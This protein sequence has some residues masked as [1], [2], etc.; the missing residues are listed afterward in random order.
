MRQSMSWVST[1][2][3]LFKELLESICHLMRLRH[4]GYNTSRA[5]QLHPVITTRRITDSDIPDT[6]AVMST[7]L[8]RVHLRQSNRLARTPRLPASADCYA[9]VVTAAATSSAIVLAPI[10]NAFNRRCTHLQAL[11]RKQPCSHAMSRH[12]GSAPRDA[13]QYALSH[14]PFYRKRLPM[15]LQAI[16]TANG[17]Y[18][19]TVQHQWPNV[20]WPSPIRILT[21]TTNPPR[22]HRSLNCLQHRRLRKTRCKG[23]RDDDLR[24]ILPSPD[25]VVSGVTLSDSSS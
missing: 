1:R 16:H 21:S 5:T 20:R 14:P 13:H 22:I 6:E 3:I 24:S 18:R 4:Q 11:F 2:D 9:N 23:K 17:L 19:D 15:V 8:T 25:A 12:P 7:T 10:V